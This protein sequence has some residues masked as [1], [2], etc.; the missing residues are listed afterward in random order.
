MRQRCAPRQR[1]GALRV[2]HRGV[3]DERVAHGAEAGQQVQLAH[4]QPWSG[5]DHD[6]MG[7]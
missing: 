6:V 4:L 5:Y 1:R 7:C 3:D 2:G